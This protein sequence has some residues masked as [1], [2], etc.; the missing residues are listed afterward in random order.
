LL[1]CKK[2]VSPH[3]GDDIKPTKTNTP[4]TGNYPAT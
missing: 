4:P 3:R 1:P 2:T